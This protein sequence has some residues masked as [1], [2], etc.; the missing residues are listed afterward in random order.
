V[1]HSPL[2]RIWVKF[3]DLPEQERDRLH[4]F[5]KGHDYLCPHC[6]NF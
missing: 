2:Y 4:C 3:T 5:A 1:K 6:E